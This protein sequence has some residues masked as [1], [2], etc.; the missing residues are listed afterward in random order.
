MQVTRIFI[1]TGL[2]STS[3]MAGC[4]IGGDSVV[5]LVGTDS[6]NLI[7]LGGCCLVLPDGRAISCS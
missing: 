3:R 2:S 5:G 1:F 6:G 4:I 7:E